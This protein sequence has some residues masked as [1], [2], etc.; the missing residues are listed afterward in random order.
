MATEWFI[1]N[2]MFANPDNSKPFCWK[3]K[4]QIT[5]VLN[6]LLAPEKFRLSSI[7]L[8]GVIIDDKL[9]F[10]LYINRICKSTSK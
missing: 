5:L 6:K 9:N 2:E 4:N 3:N 7:D 10:H 1:E 8:I